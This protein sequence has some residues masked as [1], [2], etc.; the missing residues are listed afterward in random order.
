ME[1]SIWAIILSIAVGILSNF[2]TPHVFNFLG[3]ISNSIKV[4][5]EKRK[6]VFTNSVQYLLDNP[7]EELVFRI[8][9]MF[10]VLA[11]GLAL[12]FAVSLMLSTNSIAVAVGFFVSLLIYFS[13][14]KIDNRRRIRQELIKIKKTG[15][16]KINLD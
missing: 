7:H 3:K 13:M 14:F 4:S 5:N 1:L 15:Q 2:L 12:F 10:T 11:I 6:I 9:Y 16:P 8:E